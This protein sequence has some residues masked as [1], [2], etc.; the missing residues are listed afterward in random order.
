[1]SET[2]SDTSIEASDIFSLD[3][4]GM[5]RRKPRAAPTPSLAARGRAATWQSV[6]VAPATWH[7]LGVAAA[8]VLVVPG[9]AGAAEGAGE[10]FGKFSRFRPE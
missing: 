8:V 2:H 6:G 9:S 1:V 3:A 10:N 4:R 5:T 7:A